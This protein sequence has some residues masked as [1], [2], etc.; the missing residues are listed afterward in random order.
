MMMSSRVQLLDFDNLA[1]GAL[2]QRG[3][4]FIWK[5]R[6]NR[7]HRGF[8]ELFSGQ[9]R[10]LKREL[11]FRAS[12]LHSATEHTRPEEKYIIWQRN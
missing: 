1:E 8:S 10:E 2:P 5:D 3:E 11:E 12:L 7:P 4:D 9:L 6:E